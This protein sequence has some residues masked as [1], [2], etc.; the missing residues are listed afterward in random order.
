MLRAAIANTIGPKSTRASTDMVFN[1]TSCSG[2]LD[3]LVYI[4]VQRV[5][6]L[7]RL[8]AKFPE[9][10]LIVGDIIHYCNG[11]QVNED[12]SAGP[13]SM[14]RQD[15]NDL[16][17][18]LTNELIIK[19]EGEADID[20]INMPWQ[21]LKKAVAEL[22][23]R[24]RNKLAAKQRTHLSQV[25]EIDNQMI[26]KIVNKLGPKEQKV[27]RHIA[28]GGAWAD[29][30]LAD[31]GQ[32]DGLCPHCDKQVNDITHILWECEHIHKHR[33]H[34]DLCDMDHAQLPL[35]IKHGV[36]SA[37]TNDIQAPYW[38]KHEDGNQISNNKQFCK[39]IGMWTGKNSANIMSSKHQEV[40]DAL[41]NVGIDG[42]KQNAR[43]AF[44]NAKN[45]K[46]PPHFALPHKCYARAPNEINVYS[47]GSWLFPL[48]Q[49]LG[50]GGAGV[51]WPGRNIN[52]S[53]RPSPAEREL[54]YHT[55]HEEGL[56]LHTP[57]GGMSG[58]STRTELA[59]AI[60]AIAANGPIHLGTDSKAFMERANKVIQHIRKGS[61]R[62]R[63]WQ[64]C[65]DGDLWYHFEHAVRAKGW[66]AVRIT[67]VKG[68]V[69]QEQV[70]A[71]VFR[72]VDKDGND[73]ADKAA[74]IS[75]N[76]HG[77]GLISAGR[78][79]HQRYLA[80]L[81]FIGQVVPHIT[82]AYLIH[83]KLLEITGKD[84]AKEAHEIQYQPLAIDQNQAAQRFNM[85]S[86]IV[87]FR[88][89][90]GRHTC[91]PDIWNFMSQINIYKTD[92]DTHAATWLEL[93]ILYR[94]RANPKP[95]A[96]DRNRARTRAGVLA[97]LNRFK[98]VVRGVM[99]RALYN[100]DEAELLKP[101]KVRKHKFWYLGLQ[102]KYAAVS[103]GIQIGTVTAGILEHNIIT[104]SRQLAA[105]KVQ[106]YREGQIKLKPAIAKLKARVG[107]DSTIKQDPTHQQLNNQHLQL[108]SYTPKAIKR[109]SEEIFYRS[110]GFP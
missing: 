63:N 31:I 25:D 40:K 95:I 37:M 97:Q 41:S 89:F 51:W 84:K 104:L 18:G 70:D 52:I 47:D 38:S 60:M 53:H 58:S 98:T 49:Y 54:G 27:Y 76:L 55:Q 66:K 48:N 65:S 82:E 109:K 56:S 75:A 4:M 1:C 5:T 57:I 15:L 36:P 99:S 30:H 81:K 28:T 91:A 12:D 64:M 7:K 100:R 39:Q 88:A 103:F 21:H 13:V 68:H 20:I 9:V 93:Y 2:D 74:E 43:Q 87:N 3:P 11:K 78:I 110:E 102:G 101:I 71:G 105:K 24:N 16:G 42:T 34:R 19:I 45:N 8:M 72:Q 22:V 94:M 23:I 6:A 79:L 46:Q 59:A 85:Q 80:Y 106:M 86:S 14:L 50:L 96:D 26:K 17:A 62:K 35:H 61:K 77:E 107:W 44:T 33:K 83:R 108:V 10:V 32:S 73:R 69:K 92:S 67:K 90:S 29:N